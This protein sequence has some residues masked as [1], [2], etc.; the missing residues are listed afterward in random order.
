MCPCTPRTSVW[1]PPSVLRT[2]PPNEAILLPVELHFP[3]TGMADSTAPG[4]HGVVVLNNSSFH[5]NF[6]YSKWHWCGQEQKRLVELHNLWTSFRFA[7]WWKSRG[8]FSNIVFILCITGKVKF[9]WMSRTRKILSSDDAG[10]ILGLFL[11]TDI[12]SGWKKKISSSVLNMWISY[13]LLENTSTGRR[14]QTFFIS[15]RIFN[16]GSSIWKKVVRRKTRK[17]IICFFPLLITFSVA[18]CIQS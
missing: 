16:I 15:A 10:K 8:S 7:S 17:V 5:C 9:F 6:F 13:L 1:S 4:F 3:S 18:Q 11:S 2:N 12:I 14:K